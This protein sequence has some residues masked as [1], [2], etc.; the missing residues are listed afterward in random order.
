MNFFP[1]IQYLIQQDYLTK[2]K[3]YKLNI[4]LTLHGNVKDCVPLIIFL[5]DKSEFY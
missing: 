1:T 4:S 5:A 3:P 2:F